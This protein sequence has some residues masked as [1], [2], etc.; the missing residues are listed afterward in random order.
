MSFSFG[1]IRT[2][3]RLI[4][5]FPLPKYTVVRT[6]SSVLV[7]FHWGW[8]RVTGMTPVLRQDQ[9]LFWPS[10]LGSPFH[11]Q[12]SAAQR[13]SSAFL[14]LQPDTVDWLV[15]NL[16]SF[17]SRLL[18]VAGA[19]VQPHCIVTQQRAL[20]GYTEWPDWLRL[21][22]TD[23]SRVPIPMTTSPVTS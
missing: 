12:Y 18:R 16:G 5:F 2:A 4:H 19:Q 7:V 1:S 20:H 22:P 6:V 9:I 17:S 8:G 15:E 13:A 3:F 10:L 23:A 14:W 11:G 21:L